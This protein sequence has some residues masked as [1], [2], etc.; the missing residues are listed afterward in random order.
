MTF[1]ESLFRAL[2]VSERKPV[3]GDVRSVLPAVVPRHRAEEAD[4]LVA[5]R[6]RVREVAVQVREG[7]AAESQRSSGLLGTPRE[8]LDHAR[9][10]RDAVER[11]LR[12]LDDLDAVDVLDGDLREGG[13]EGASRRNAV[14]G[15]E[16]RV[17]LLQAPHPDV[18]EPA[19][20]VRPVAGIEA[21]DV[22]ERL[23]DGLARPCRRSSSPETT[24]TGAATSSASSSALRRR[25]DHRRRRSASGREPV[26]GAPCEARETGPAKASAARE[27]RHGTHVN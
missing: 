4:R 13:V 24:E 26:R 27:E 25:D 3:G 16:E 14:H 9:E 1:H 21:H 23:G 7:A 19:A 2:R 5:L 6:S 12:A 22:L 20:V 18:R 17:E 11:A 15:D 8:D 10:G